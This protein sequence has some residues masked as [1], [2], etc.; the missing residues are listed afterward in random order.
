M[1]CGSG[2]AHGAAIA[3]RTPKTWVDTLCPLLECP[4]SPAGSGY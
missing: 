4:N 2:V 3:R 1:I